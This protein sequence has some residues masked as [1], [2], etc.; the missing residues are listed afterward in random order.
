MRKIIA[1]LFTVITIFAIKETIYIF[2]S[3]DPDIAQKKNQYS[4]VALS[5]T[6][7]LSLFTLWLWS[8]KR[9]SE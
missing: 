8:G 3:T 9:K 4:I 2:T 7:P 5:L 1:V 6:L